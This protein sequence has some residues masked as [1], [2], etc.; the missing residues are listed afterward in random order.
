MR[1]G[2]LAVALA[3]LLLALAACTPARNVPLLT[4]PTPETQVITVT[5]A[6]AMVPLLDE[7]AH[8]YM[9][10]YP[11]TVVE[12]TGGGS[13]WGVQAVRAGQ[14]EIGMLSRP[15]AADERERGGLVETPIARDGIALIVNP[16]NPINRLTRAQ[17]PALW[18]GDTF[19]WD[20]LGWLAGPIQLVSREEGSGDRAV[21]L[22]VA[23]PNGQPLA[24]NALLLPTPD[25]VVD[26]VAREPSALGYVSIS[27]LTPAVKGL[28][29]D[30]TPPT[31]DALAR[32][33]YPIAR[34][35]V[36]LTRGEPR[37]ASR[38]FLEWIRSEEAQHLIARRHLPL[39]P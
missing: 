18:G 7:L 37:G 21:F 5:G 29:L 28:A 11:K 39:A 25:A 8:A 32:G 4:R 22:S 16:A 38:H 13:G 27:A 20:E 3:S 33:N 24:L 17:L 23:L 14:A 30:D 1:C 6:Q 35:L 36:L 12:V 9:Q 34:D 10:A 31:L 15:L 19:L 2:G 26:F